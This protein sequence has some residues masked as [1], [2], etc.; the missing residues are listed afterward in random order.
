MKAIAVRV[1]WLSTTM[2]V[3]ACSDVQSVMTP[4]GVQADRLTEL[5]WV[6]F[7]GGTIIF[8][9]VMALAAA[10]LSRRD[11]IRAYLRR[12]QAVIWGGLVFPTVTL[13]VLLIYGLL[14]TRAGALSIGSGVSLRVHVAGELWWW[15][16]TYTAPDGQRI[17]SANELRI[18]VG[19]TVEIALTSDNVIHSFWVP[20]LA[21]KLD[22]IPGRT[23][24]LH[25][26]ASEPGTSR[27]QCAEYCG[28]PHALMSFYVVA[29]P[30]AAF[31]AWLARESGAARTF[32]DASRLEGQRLFLASGCGA[33]HTVR[34]TPANG[35]IGP[36]LTHVGSRQSLAAATLPND[37][38]SFMRWIRD[39]HEVKPQ[40]LMPP[41]E[42]FDD[43][44]LAA[45]AAYLSSLE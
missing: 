28:G 40:N 38:A 2:V 8:L 27:G 11:G 25:L 23:N 9:V 26:S 10:A 24:V 18:P 32:D 43:A 36:D 17:E 29:M 21:G 34:G 44:A 45:L 3:G 13:T 6:L 4:K 31:D 12:E 19:R 41:Y 30:Q 1:V 42:I 5:S 33:C 7:V 35:R 22:V 20:S 37:E 15:R 14:V 39:S 16:V